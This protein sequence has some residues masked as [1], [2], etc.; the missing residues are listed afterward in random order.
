MRKNLIF[1]PFTEGD[2]GALRVRKAHRN[3]FALIAN[4]SQDS[5]SKSYEE[6]MWLGA[7]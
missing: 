2:F 5:A 3:G 1:E 7:K 6:T 4:F